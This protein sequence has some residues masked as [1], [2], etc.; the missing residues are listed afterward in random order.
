MVGI[1]IL[2]PTVIPINSYINSSGKNIIITVL[3]KTLPIGIFH[4]YLK[5]IIWNINRDKN[6]LPQ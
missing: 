2:I 5:N 6:L 1:T 3:L 4:M